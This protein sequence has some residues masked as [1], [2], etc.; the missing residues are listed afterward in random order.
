M[1]VEVD[2][3]RGRAAAAGGSTTSSGSSP[4]RR[5]ART[6][7]VADAQRRTYWLDRLNLDLD[8]T[9]ATTAGPPRRCSA[10]SAPSGAPVGCAAASGGCVATLTV[11]V[12]AIIP[13]KDGERYLRGAPRR[14]RARGRRRGAHRR[15]GIERRQRRHRP[16]RRR[17]VEEIAP[18]EFGHGR[19]RNL[20]AELATGDVSA[21]LTQ[22]ATPVPGWR[23]AHL[24]ALALGARRRRQLRPASSAAGH[25]PD[26]RPRAHGVLRRD[27]AG[28]AAG[29]ARRRATRRSSRTSTPP[30]GARAGRQVRFRELAYSED[31]AFGRDMLAAGWKKAYHPARGRAARARLSAGGSS[32]SA[33][34]T[35]TAGC[36]RRPGTSSAFRLREVAGA[37]RAAVRADLAFVAPAQRLAGARRRAGRRGRR[38][39]TPAGGRSPRSAR[40][41]DALPAG[42]SQPA[43]ARAPRRDAAAAPAVP[44]VDA[45][46]A[47]AGV[48]TTISTRCSASGATAPAPLLPADPA[49]RRPATAARRRGHPAVPRGVRRAPDDLHGGRASS[50]AWAT[51]ARSGSTT[52]SASTAAT[53]GLACCGTAST[54]GS[55]RSTR[56]VHYGFDKWRG[57]DVVARDGL[58]DGVPRAAARPGRTPAPTSSRTTSRSSTPPPS[59]RGSRRRLSRGPVRHRREP[60]AAATWSGERY[61]AD[62]AAFELGVDT[63]IYHPVP[64]IERE[65]RTVVFYS[66]VVTP[67]RATSLGW[68]ALDR[69]QAA[70][71][72]RPRHRVRR[73]RSPPASRRSCTTTPAS[74]R[75]AELAALY[76]LGTVGLVLSMTNYSLI[77]QEMLACGLP[78]RRPRRRLAARRC[79]AGRAGRARARSTRSLWPTRSSGCSTTTCCGRQPDRRAVCVDG[80]RRGTRGRAGRAR[81]AAGTCVSGWRARPLT[82]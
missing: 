50:S 69:A 20:A 74:S 31:Q 43:V 14:A 36:T 65:P 62:G 49:L 41:R 48:A 23:A 79:S 32:C 18:A 11:R 71:A 60:V 42:R 34:S 44:P 15:L 27:G 39:I 12:S 35:S 21:F 67:R 38:R 76:S 58:A 46:D 45:P 26:D 68:L 56:P 52:R 54:S 72:G 51:P 6:R 81:A 25:E 73:R 2:A 37:T 57:A 40:A 77:P 66:R 7:C 8:V 80:G 75:P 13:V 16:G 4:R 1:S 19:T 63:T 59:S 22:D 64:G 55:G 5:L 3:G 70:D 33:T 47:G 17:A 24:E 29:R 53:D 28:R 10:P 78:V 61:G 9:L 30:T 82:P